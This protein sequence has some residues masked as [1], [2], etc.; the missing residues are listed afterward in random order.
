MAGAAGRAAPDSEAWRKA[1]RSYLPPAEGTD[2]PEQDI[3]TPTPLAL[4][5][6]LRELIPRTPSRWN[7]PVSKAAKATAGDLGNQYRLGV[8]PVV[9]TSRGWARSGITWTN[10]PHLVNRLNLDPEQH[11]WFC[12]FGALHLA[13]RPTTPGRDPDWIYLDDFANPVLWTLLDQTPTLSIQLV[14]SGTNAAVIRAKTATLTLDATK[15]EAGI[16]VRP[17]LTIDD[18]RADE[19]H[20]RPIGNHGLYLVDPQAPRQILIAPTADPLSKDQLAILS[21]RTKTQVPQQDADDF[22]ENYLPELQE[23]IDVTSSDKSVKLPTPKPPVLILTVTHSPRHTITLAWRWQ[24]GRCSAPTPSLDQIL[25]KGLLPDEW[26]GT[27]L[28]PRI[29]P[30]PVT[31][32]GIDAAVFAARTLRTLH[33]LPGVAVETQGLAPDYRELTGTP[34]L[35]I[36]TVPSEKH[37]WF[38]LGVVVTV[39]GR[40]IP[41]LPL[42]K[43]LAKG[44]RRLLLVDGSYLALNHPALKALSDLIEESRDLT[45]WEPVPS[46]SRHQISLWSD[47]EDL[48]DEAVPA[49]EWRALLAE[50]R[51]DSPVPVDPPKGLDAILRPY[52]QDGFAWLAYLWRHRLGGILADDMGL[53]K[54]VQCL[55][56]IQHIV[57][58]EKRDVRMPFLIVAPTS[59]MTNWVTEAEKFTPGLVVRQMST[60]E[61]TGKVP[62]ADVARG[63]DVVVTSYALLRLDFDAYQAVAQS[64]GWAG[65]MLDEAQFVKNSGSKVHAAALDLQ[66]P[67]KLAVTGTPLENSLTDLQA[68][69]AIVAPGLFASAPRFLN[70]Y[71]RPIEQS[72]PGIARGIGA[73]N[74]EQVN[75]A[76]RVERLAKLRRRIRP[77][78]LRRTKELVAAD[79][80]AKQEQTLRIDLAPEH[81]DLYDLFLQRERQKLF[82]LL[83]DDFNLNKFIVFRSLTLLRLLALDASLIGDEYGEMPSS[84]LDAL[85]EQLDDVVAE[86]HRALIFSQFTSYLA[87]VK[88]R[89]DLAGISFV[90]LDGSTRNRAEVIAEF[91]T[92]TAPVFLISLKA[93]GFGLNLTEADYVFLLDPWWNPASEEQA[94]DRT[95]R[96]GQDKNV[97]VYRLVAADTIEEKVLALQE[98]KANL[99][100]SVIDDEAL[101]SAALTVDDIRELLG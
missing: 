47:F 7:G 95:H 24:G 27:E 92:G 42:F 74:T 94:I 25:P 38:D 96:I 98:R 83:G 101:F 14:G 3:K 60:T 9:R 45:E 11:R 5:F 35:V 48:A 50:T 85:F 43:A 37:D 22:L 61:A 55:T 17:R 88:R 15:D 64:S 71:V 69:F 6:E 67:F 81:R 39:D 62:I 49:V 44:R 100:N 59:V 13:L 63:A 29:V 20:T 30:L 58:A 65:L 57:E 82:R 26:L 91:K 40:N 56:L 32:K 34:Q 16:Q 75:A 31:L 90:Y 73:G 72:R 52:Q 87:K 68:L 80:P 2:Q 23:R 18:T 12:E 19:T 97:M 79:L 86:G 41:F 10:I 76:T 99:F 70:D 54:T 8:R 4:Q 21:E 46:I 33:R 53:G 84:K 36:T 89:L 78:L 1:L 51:N 28:L 77:F 66:V 93:G